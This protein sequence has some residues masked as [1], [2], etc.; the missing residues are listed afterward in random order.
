MAE[1]TVSQRRELE[2]YQEYIDYSSRVVEH[3]GGL[4]II[5]VTGPSAVGS[6]TIIKASGLHKVPGFTTRPPRY[7][8]ESEIRF[9]PHTPTVIDEIIDQAK[10]GELVQVKIRED[11]FVYGSEPEDYWSRE[12]NVVDMTADAIIKLADL[13]LGDLRAAVILCSPDEWEARFLKDRGEFAQCTDRIWGDIVSLRQTEESDY[14]YFVPIINNDGGLEQ[15][16]QDFQV[17]AKEGDAA[18]DHEE[19]LEASA[20]RDQL[21]A[22]MACFV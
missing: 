13:P 18:F 3:L 11:N 17:V 7:E 19:L 1:V 14:P 6:T 2:V 5:G 21:L 20:L 8:G 9:K 15:A 4:V 10:A 12:P 22:R 16:V